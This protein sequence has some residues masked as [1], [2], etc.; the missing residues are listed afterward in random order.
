MTDG[1]TRLL[2][3]F[4]LKLG[5][6]LWPPSVVSSA[7]YGFFSSIQTSTVLATAAMDTASTTRKTA[8]LPVKSPVL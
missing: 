7:D 1:F 6:L 5:P 8:G 4:I 2:D 3:S